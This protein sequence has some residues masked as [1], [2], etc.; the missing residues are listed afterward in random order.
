MRVVLVYI[1]AFYFLGTA[2]YIFFWPQVFYAN[3]P[4]VSAMGPFNLHFIRDVALAFLVSGAGMLYGVR[5]GL[6]GVMVIGA[7]WPFLHA[8][9]HLYIWGKR[10]FPFD[11]I[12]ASDLGLVI[13]PAFLAMFL[14]R[15]YKVTKS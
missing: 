10:G 11:Q 12:W 6:R 4:G 9:F 14:A 1:L 7:A 15:T 8:I 3:T 5:K 2:I 13:V